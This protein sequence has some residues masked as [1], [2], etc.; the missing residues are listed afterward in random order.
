MNRA[1]LSGFLAILA[2]SSTVAFS[3]ALGESLGALTSGAIIYSLGGL[4]GLLAAAR[5]PG[6]LRRFGAQP[7]RYLLGC[8][9]L[10][11]I[12]MI[13]LYLA[14]GL[15]ESRAQVLAIGLANYLWPALIMLFSIPI[16]GNRP[17]PWLAPGILLALA[18]TGLAVFADGPGDLAGLLRA[19]NGLLPVE[20]ALGAALAWGLYSN[21]ARRWASGEGGAVPLFLLAS[22]LAFLLLRQAAGESSRWDWSLVPTLVYMAL[23]P[24]WLGYQLWD[25]AM[26]RGDL[27]LVTA[28]SYF[29]PLL[30]TLISLLVLGIAPSPQLGLAALLVS[31]GAVLSKLGVENN[32]R[33]VGTV[34][35]AAQKRL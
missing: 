10:F 18:G 25:F 20:L 28:A 27:T 9:S 19:R 32:D 7:R 4:F 11:V 30:S 22:G 33:R 13:L 8:G 14:I 2:W 16:L 29:T 15:A 31:L 21:L 5:Q 1:T 17:R 23:F 35:R 6:G 3:R 12:Y 34:T 26:Q 24:A